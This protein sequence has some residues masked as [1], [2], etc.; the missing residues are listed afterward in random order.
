[1]SNDKTKFVKLANP[2]GSFS[3]GKVFVTGKYAREVKNN[4]LVMQAIGAGRLVEVTKAEYEKSRAELAE[5]E[6]KAK[7]EEPK[8]QP[9]KT[10]TTKTKGAETPTEDPKSGE[11]PTETP[12]K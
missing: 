9:K 7:G 8:E 12:P 3:D 4:P 10:T 11:T 2:N 6:A 5:A 1:M